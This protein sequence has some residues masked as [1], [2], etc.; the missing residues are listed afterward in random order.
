V[1]RPFSGKHRYATTIPADVEEK[2]VSSRLIKARRRLSEAVGEA[3]ITTVDER[4]GVV[5]KSLVRDLE[6]RVAEPDVRYDAKRSEDQLFKQPAKWVSRNIKLFVPLSTFLLSV[7]KDIQTGTELQNRKKRAEQLLEILSGFGPAIIK[8][9]QALAS[10]PDLLPN[11]YLVELQK[12]QDRVPPF[13]DEEAFAVIEEEL[14]RPFDEV[15]ELISNGPIAAASIGQ[16]YKARLK[17]NGAEIAL[18]V[19]RPGC[20][21]IIALD[22]YVLRFYSGL[23]NQVVDLLNKDIDLEGIIDD[24]GELIYREIDYRAEAANAQRFSELYAGIPDVFVPKIYP[25]LSTKK[26]LTMEWVDGARLTDTDQIQ[27]YGLDS[28]KLVDTLVQC[29][30]RQM[31]ENGFFHADP[32]GGNLLATP[33]GKLCY[34]DFGMMSY[35][36]AHQRYGII[37]AVVHLVN[38]DFV[39]LTE[40][41]KRLKFIPEDID[42]Q[43]VIIA[44]ERALPDVL[45]AS[46][47]ELNF[48]NVISKLGDIFYEFPF[49]LPPYY[50]A[51]IRC[52]GVLE[53]LAIQIDRDFKILKDAYPYIASRLLT[54]SAPELQSA[55]QQLVFKDGIPR[56]DRLEEL[57]E[58]ATEIQDYDVTLAI[59]QGIDYLLSDDGEEMLSLL[60][61]QIVEVLDRLGYDSSRYLTTNIPNLNLQS[62]AT[63]STG[64]QSL[65]T[66]NMSPSMQSTVRIV[67]ILS[68]SQGFNIEKVWPVLRRLLIEPKTQKLGV[69]MGSRLAERVISRSVR[70]VFQLPQPTFPASGKL[71]IEN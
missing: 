11:E 41:Y 49:S 4:T 46:V 62:F 32:H 31:L 51:I 54:D 43:P 18:K 52:L 60:A 10:R 38:R 37:E 12:L 26:I 5:K 19:Q 45:T 66:S 24:F 21:D 28:S 34:L 57:L 8:A 44:L 70:R 13:S 14:G 2:E 64:L 53:G 55:M 23:L 71:K 29:S 50:I 16:V 27:A 20:E 39:S 59:N 7:I 69:Q 33:D 6:I 47:G 67:D 15:F 58:E 17:V 25:N 56:W 1:T 36:E 40:L 22:L 63:F 9:G 42:P 65:D 68:R 61:Y 3:P 48:K 35:V 30:L